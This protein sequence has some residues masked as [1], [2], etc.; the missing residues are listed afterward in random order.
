MR[1]KIRIFIDMD[2]SIADIHRETNWFDR[3][4]V[5]KDFF[6][7][8]EP[9]NNLIVAL[10]LVQFYYGKRVKMYSLSSVED[11]DKNSP[12]VKAKNKWLDNFAQFIPRK[13]RIFTICGSPKTMYIK[14]ISE[15]DILLDDYSKNLQ[16]WVNVGGTGIKVR[17]NINCSG[18][19]WT[20]NVIYNQDAISS[21]VSKLDDVIKPLL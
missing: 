13:R 19:N 1:K 5:E 12:Y 2:G 15:R 7:N 8:L 21:I 11:N 6:A 17:N 10:A 16:D 9:F 20:G 18:V 4:K 14:N 3:V